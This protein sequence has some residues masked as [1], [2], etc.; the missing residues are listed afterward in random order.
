[1]ALALA[2]TA[3]FPM[4]FLKSFA[5]GPFM[6]KRSGRRDRRPPDSGVLGLG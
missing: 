6:A 4:Y 2:A 1:V 5:V 3:P